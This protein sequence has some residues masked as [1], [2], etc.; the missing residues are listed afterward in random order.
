[1]GAKG[2]TRPEGIASRPLS[3]CSSM[4]PQ[5]SAILWIIPQAARKGALAGPSRIAPR[6]NLTQFATQQR[7]FYTFS[8]GAS[9]P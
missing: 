1:V 8:T 3:S 7:A 4:T 6:W 2:R 5:R 9:R